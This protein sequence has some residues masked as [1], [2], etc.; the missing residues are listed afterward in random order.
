MQTSNDT[1]PSALRGCLTVPAVTWHSTH[2]TR[3]C[4]PA[5]NASSW[6]AIDSP[7]SFVNSASSWQFR[8]LEFGIFGTSAAAAAASVAAA[9]WAAA[10]TAPA[11]VSS[12]AD[13]P[14]TGRMRRRSR[15][16]N[17]RR[18]PMYSRRA[19]GVARACAPRAAAQHACEFDPSAR[20]AIGD[21]GGQ[22]GQR[23]QVARHDQRVAP[24]IR[25][26]LDGRQRRQALRREHEPGQQRQRRGQA[27]VC[28]IIGTS[29]RGHVVRCSTAIHR[30]QRAD[31]HF[32]RRE[33]RHQRERD[34]PVEADR[35]EHDSSAR[36]I[37]PAKLYWMAGPSRRAAAPDSCS[38][39]TARSS[40][41]G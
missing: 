1:G 26:A 40:A 18:T 41:R 2:S 5:L 19:A 34:L 7:A 13:R 20:H 12:S 32:A 4:A 35:R 8:H 38:G 28:A 23:E 14:R 16:R 39:T 27:P 33:A 24:G 30:A 36:P 11:S 22:V 21:E 9:S 3:L 37:M 15:V 6:T 29:V 10:G 31:G 25:L 17:M